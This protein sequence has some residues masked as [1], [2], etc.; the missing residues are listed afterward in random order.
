MHDTHKSLLLS[1]IVKYRRHVGTPFPPQSWLPRKVA[2]SA[3]G[4]LSPA[5]KPAL[6]LPLQGLLL[7]A[8]SLRLKLFGSL[9]CLFFS[10]SK[11]LIE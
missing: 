4:V 7:R 11:R 8:L 1:V 10:V 9:I 3:S 2:V 5:L 6:S